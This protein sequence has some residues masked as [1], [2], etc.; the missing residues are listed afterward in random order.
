VQSAQKEPHQLFAKRE[1][2]VRDVKI[3]ERE[4][5]ESHREP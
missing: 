2:E 1:R 3:D 5:T 4:T